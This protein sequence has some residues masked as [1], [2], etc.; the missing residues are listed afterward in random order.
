MKLYI[1]MYA[2]HIIIKIGFIIILP[3]IIIG[4]VFPPTTISIHEILT[5]LFFF[6]GNIDTNIRQYQYTFVE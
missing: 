6:A 4:N 5:F 3:V 2:Q 1:Y